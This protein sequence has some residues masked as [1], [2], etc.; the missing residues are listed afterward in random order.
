[1]KKTYSRILAGILAAASVV[2][3]SACSD[4]GDG[5]T[6]AT[7]AE[8][9]T[10]TAKTEWTGDNIEVTVAEDAV[11]TDIN[12]E[13]KTLKWMGFYDLNPTND[14]PERSP[15]V[16]IL[17][18]TYGA[19]IEYIPTTTDQQYNDLATA[20]LGGSS[21]D[22]FVYDFRAFP[23]DISKGMYQPIDSLVDWNDP[24][25]ADVKDAAD[26]FVWNG[27]HYVAPFSYR[28][29][30]YVI[31]M[32]NRTTV[33]EMGVEDPYEL[34]LENKWDWDAFMNIMDEFQGG[35]ENLYGISGFWA[36][37]FVYTAGDVMVNYDG[38]KFSNNLYSAKIE[39]AQRVISD[40]FARGLIKR[41]WV[42]PEAAFP[43]NDCLFYAMGTWAYNSAAESMPDDVIQ[44]VPFPRNPDLDD[45]YMNKVLFS[46]MWVKGSD[47]ADC[48]KVWFDI[49]RM[50]NS[51]EQYLKIKKEKY[52]AN[53]TAWTSDMYDL[54]YSFSDDEKFI[55]PYEFGLGISEAMQGD[56]GYIRFLY[57]CI[58]N[59]QYESWEQAREEYMNIIDSELAIYNDN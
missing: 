8:S 57:E 38:S 50:V 35:D 41:G 36:N 59:E 20:V 9:T 3:L 30:D 31:L 34:Y 29:D 6:D 42:G 24:L 33:E 7:T 5:T 12:I 51:E 55:A 49:N 48:V 27:E 16:A 53:N 32:Y 22:I 43:T 44:I 54:V 39:K 19:K 56:S 13:G 26:N 46:H 15:E 45:Y 52:L 47:N 17:E 11:N 37:S 21:P 1:M 40:M 23:Y 25:W 18:D 28:F 14:N 10:T 2:S 4:S 58:Y